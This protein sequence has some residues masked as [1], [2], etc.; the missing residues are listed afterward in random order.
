MAIKG[1]GGGVPLYCQER[2]LKGFQEIKL[3]LLSFINYTHSFSQPTWLSINNYHNLPLLLPPGFLFPENWAPMPHPNTTVHTVQLSSDSS[4]YQDV[5]DKLQAT[6]STLNVQKIER[7]QNPHLYQTYM[8]K[9]QKMDQ[10][11]GGVESERQLFHGTRG[12]NVSCINAQGFNRNF[13]RLHGELQGVSI[14]PGK[15][16]DEH[17][18]PDSSY[19]YGPFFERFHQNNS[20][21]CLKALTVPETLKLM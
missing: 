10:D 21:N 2:V 3:F 19:K 15:S 13:C 20:F 14:Q 7:I 18:N 5:M 17:F 12:E 8:L 6:A 9:K 1:G 11:N 4:E 16:E